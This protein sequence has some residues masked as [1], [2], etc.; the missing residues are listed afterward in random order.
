MFT[1][2]DFRDRLFL[3]FL[4]NFRF[5]SFLLHHLF[6]FTALAIDLYAFDETDDSRDLL[7]Q[8]PLITLQVV[9]V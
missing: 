4:L 8:V 6:I 1:L 9:D 5:L 2:F 3:N 7:V